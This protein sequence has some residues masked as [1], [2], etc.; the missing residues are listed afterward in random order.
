MDEA[1]CPPCFGYERWRNREGT[2]ADV[3]STDNKSVGLD[4][5]QVTEL[6]YELR[7]EESMSPG[8]FDNEHI[9]GVIGG[10][11][12]IIKAENINYTYSEGGP[13]ESCLI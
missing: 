6:M 2:P 8:C 1:V 10:I 11:V 7:K 3:F 12:L 5:P 9:R 13:F 4:V